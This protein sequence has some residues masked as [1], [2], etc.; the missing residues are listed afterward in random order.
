MLLPPEFSSLCCIK[1]CIQL[2]ATA[3]LPCSSCDVVGHRAL[4]TV[5]LSREAA[6][7]PNTSP[8]KAT[9]DNC[10][11]N[12]VTAEFQSQDKLVYMLVARMQPCQK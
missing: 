6:I 9:L 1:N 4:M 7:E 2:I 5:L 10:F 11:A 8:T 12:L 3:K